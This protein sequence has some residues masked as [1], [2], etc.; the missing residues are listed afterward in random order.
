VLLVYSVEKRIMF[1]LPICVAILYVV[2]ILYIGTSRHLR[3]LDM[4]SRSAVYSSF[5]ETVGSV[6][7]IS[8]H[9]I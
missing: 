7:A 8:I 1:A 6:H 9:L 4:E 2:R 5:V 3:A